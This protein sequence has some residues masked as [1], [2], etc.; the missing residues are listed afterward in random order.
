MIGTLLETLRVDN[1]RILEGGF[2]TFIVISDAKRENPKVAI[3][4]FTDVGVAV[5]TNG[6]PIQTQELK[7]TFARETL[8]ELFETLPDIGWHMSIK[9]FGIDNYRVKSIDRNKTLDMLVFY[10]EPLPKVY[11][12]GALPWQDCPQAYHS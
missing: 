8:M 5:D 2:S 12:K 1:K 6:L 3:G 10:L 9:R 4:Q 7:A 11:K